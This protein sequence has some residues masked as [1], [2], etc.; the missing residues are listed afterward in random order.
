MTEPLD[1]RQQCLVRA[2]TGDYILRAEKLYRQAFE[3]IP[4]L[5]DLGGRCAGMFRARHGECC[6]R[7][8]PWIFARYFEENL[9]ATVPHEV[10]HYIVHRLHGRRRLRQHG[11]E[12]RS[13]MAAF[14]ADDSVTCDFDLTDIPLRRERRFSYRCSCRTHEITTRR[15]N[16]IQ[17]SNSRYE[18]RYC[19][20]E[21]QRV[22]SLSLPGL[23]SN[24]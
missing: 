16:A 17:R 5:F 14:Q 13:V 9:S 1:H 4:I 8:N 3:P 12:W 24:P 19:R 6:I 7:Y 23:P 2:A 11:P 21:L 15:H 18:C 22:E 20:G 10:A